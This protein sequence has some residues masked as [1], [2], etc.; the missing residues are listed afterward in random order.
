M[1]CAVS[2]AG[3]RLMCVHQQYPSKM[4]DGR[5]GWDRTVRQ[6]DRKLKE[7]DP[8]KCG[9]VVVDVCNRMIRSL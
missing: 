9:T 6:K 2:V 7:K 8:D 5:T 3:T 4:P 1:S